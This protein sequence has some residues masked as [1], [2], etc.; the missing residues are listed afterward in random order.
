MPLFDLKCGKCEKQIEV[1]ES[2]DSAKNHKCET[3]GETMQIVPSGSLF[4]VHG[5]SFANGYHRETINY[6]NSSPR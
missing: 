2:Y 5:Y 3:C 6:D 1:R 4:K